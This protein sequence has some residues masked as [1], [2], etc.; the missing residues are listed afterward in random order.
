MRSDLIMLFGISLLGSVSAQ[1]TPSARPTYNWEY[2]TAAPTRAPVAPLPPTPYSRTGWVVV[3]M[4]TD[5]GCSVAGVNNLISFSEGLCVPSSLDIGTKVSDYNSGIA[6]GGKENSAPIA[7]PTYAISTVQGMVLSSTQYADNL[8]TRRIS[9][10]STSQL[11]PSLL[12]CVPAE[13]Y[14]SKNPHFDSMQ[15]SQ[16]SSPD[17]PTVPFYSKRAILTLDPLCLDASKVV[18]QTL[19]AMTVGYSCNS[20]TTNGV[21]TYYNFACSGPYNVTIYTYSQSGCQGKPKVDD[22]LVKN[23]WSPTVK[24]CDVTSSGVYAMTTVCVPPGAAMWGAGGLGNGGGDSSSSSGGV[25][26]GAQTTT[27]VAVG[28]SVA[29][30]LLAAGAAFCYYYFYHYVKRS[31]PMAQQADQDQEN[32]NPTS[33]PAADKDDVPSPVLGTAAPALPRAS[34]LV[35]NASTYLHHAP[36]RMTIIPEQSNPSSATLT[37]APTQPRL[38]GLTEKASDEEL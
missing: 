36:G 5:A 20:F 31:S 34:A 32:P 8:C 10:P 23:F 4:S 37:P 33:N 21:T 9:A 22:P 19:T 28:V 14:G 3:A 17:L 24:A 25:S 2:R 18:Q 27:S 6:A 26:G 1:P 16:Y 29:V 30:L 35:S 7:N 13:T 38:S 12:S 15:I 11:S